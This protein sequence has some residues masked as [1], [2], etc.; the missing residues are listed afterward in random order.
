MQPIYYFILTLSCPINFRPVHTEVTS[1]F[2]T[3]WENWWMQ[4]SSGVV[5]D[6]RLRITCVFE[7]GS[8]FAW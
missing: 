3:E 5:R 2:L 8:I 4:Q 1:E 7:T 6:K